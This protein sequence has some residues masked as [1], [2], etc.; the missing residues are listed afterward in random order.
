[1]LIKFSVVAGPSIEMF[2]K[3]GLEMLGA[4][5]L[6]GTV[7]SAISPEDILPAVKQLE[8]KLNK[9]VGQD[10]KAPTNGYNDDVI[11]AKTRAFPLIELLNNAAKEKKSVMWDRV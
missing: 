3:E 5:G 2:E 9:K 8:S 6:S 1:M 7:P 4:M 11:D 10:Q